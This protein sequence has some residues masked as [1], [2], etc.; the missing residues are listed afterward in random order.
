[1]SVLHSTKA[2]L[3]EP[4]PQAHPGK[5][6]SEEE[7]DRWVGEKTRAEW[8][9]GEVIMMAPANLEHDDVQF[10]LRSIVTHFAQHHDLGAVHG[11]EVMIRVPQL[12]QRR[13]PDVLFVAKKRARILK[14]TIVDGPPDLIMEVVSPD[15]V[16]RDWVEKLADYERAGVKE[17]WI[18]DVAAKKLEVYS[19]S[20][21]G[22]YRRIK[23]KDGKVFS[24]V[25]K[26]FYLRREWV[27]GGRLARTMQVIKELGVEE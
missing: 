12:N 11:P 6:M 14:K 8:V 10:W 13:L 24:A 3:D 17:Y 25:M 21:D 19:L 20:K 5:R 4:W 9:N 22:K 27:L 2:W 16:E 26:G 18:V 23:E 1:M 15:S 7:F